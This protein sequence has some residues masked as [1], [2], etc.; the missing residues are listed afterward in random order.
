MNKTSYQLFRL[1]ENDQILGYMR[2]I[3]PS[4][5]FYSK[6]RLW[7]Q[8][9]RIT[10]NVKDSYTELTDQNQQWIFDKDIIEMKDNTTQFKAVVLYDIDRMDFVAVRCDTF[11]AILISK[12]K[13]YRLKIVSYLFI[14]PEIETE[15]KDREWQL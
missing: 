10:Y 8:S 1:R 3:K 6:D 11:E 14:N 9:D 15:L 13:D 5:I 7:W 12:W 4:K 2:F